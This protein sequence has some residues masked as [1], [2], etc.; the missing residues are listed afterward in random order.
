MLIHVQSNEQLTALTNEYWHDSETIAGF[1]S[2]G[3]K[4]RFPYSINNT[5]QYFNLH[6]LI[7]G[8]FSRTHYLELVFVA[9][10]NIEMGIVNAP[11]VSGRIGT[12]GNI[13]LV[14]VRKEEYGAAA[15]LLFQFLENESEFIVDTPKPV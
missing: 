8:Y 12:L 15:A 13:T 11:G 1:I 2:F 9:V 3:H 6:L 4:E 14:N 5:G 7:N 10:K